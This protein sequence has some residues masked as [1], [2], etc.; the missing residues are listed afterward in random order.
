MCVS[1]APLRSRSR[2]PVAAASARSSADADAHVRG[3]CLTSDAS[4]PLHM[5]MHTSDTD[6]S[7]ESRDTLLGMLDEMI[8]DSDQ[9]NSWITDS[10]QLRA[11]QQ[12]EQIIANTN[13]ANTSGQRHKPTICHA[14]GGTKQTA[15]DKDFWD[16]VERLLSPCMKQYWWRGDFFYDAPV[17]YDP[18]LQASADFILDNISGN[19]EY[20]IGITE[21]PMCRWYNTEMPGYEWDN[22]QNPWLFMA[23]LYAAKTSK[24]TVEHSSGSFEKE[25]CQMMEH[26]ND[27]LNRIGAGGDCPSNGSPHF[28]YVVGR[29]KVYWLPPLGSE[30]ELR[31]VDDLGCY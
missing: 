17:D 20:K 1:M 24:P 16:S 3:R 9:G 8:A 12:A 23:I 11:T 6:F 7:E 14:F 18:C 29:K 15:D 21:H 22:K 13:I 2:T 31:L 28:V 30:D 5:Q 10:E 27:C 26:D 25:L 19:F 4:A